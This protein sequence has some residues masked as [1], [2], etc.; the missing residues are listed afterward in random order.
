MA[1]DHGLPIPRRRL[2]RGGRTTL[3]GAAVRVRRLVATRPW[4]RQVTRSLALSV[5]C[6]LAACALWYLAL[7]LIASFFGYDLQP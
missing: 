3:A 6:L 4:L 7:L 5:A 2:R 1:D